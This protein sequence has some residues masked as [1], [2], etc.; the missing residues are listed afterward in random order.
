[1]IATGSSK[2]GMAGSGTNGR[3]NIG[4]ANVNQ[5]VHGAEWCGR[6]QAELMRPVTYDT[7]WAAA[8]TGQNGPGTALWCIVWPRWPFFW[9][10]IVRVTEVAARSALGLDVS[11]GKIVWPAQIPHRIHGTG[12]CVCK[13]V[14]EVAYI[15]PRRGENRM[16]G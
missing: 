11:Y 12:L 5:W 16:Q 9:L 10:S 1:M 6:R 8:L 7:W 3:Q 4:C 13:R 2:V 14:Q 15:R